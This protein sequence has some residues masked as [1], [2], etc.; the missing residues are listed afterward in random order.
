MRPTFAHAGA[1]AA[2]A[3]GAACGS[4][5]VTVRTLEAPGAAPQA[6]RT[7]EVAAPRRGTGP[8]NPAAAAEDPMADNTITSQ[9]LRTALREDFTRLG[10]LPAA[11][12]PGRRPDFVVTY[13]AAA[14]ER[15][16]PGTVNYVPVY[17]RWGWAGDRV[18]RTAPHAVERGTV[19]VDVLDGRDGHLLWRGQGVGTVADDPSAYARELERVVAAVV[20]KFPHEA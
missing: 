20:R 10:Y 17:T 6:M 13:Y 16:E 9:A 15:L 1:L 11:A 3:F 7:F 14:R 18:Y 2:V 5:A 8:A 19:V 4:P 12:T